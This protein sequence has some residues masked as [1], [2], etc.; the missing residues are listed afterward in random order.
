MIENKL[1]Y[2]TAFLDMNRQNWTSFSRTFDDYLTAFTPYIDMF[3]KLHD[4]KNMLIYNYEM[5]IYIDEIHYDKILA[6][7]TKNIPVKVIK[8]NR[9]FLQ[10]HFPMW[11]LLDR[12]REIMNSDHYKTTF[13][14]R[15]NF[16][17]NTIPEYTMINH[18]KI[19]FLKHS[20]VKGMTNSEFICWTDFGYFKLDDYKMENPLDLNCFNKNT[21]NYSII[22]PI[23]DS[24]LDV[25][26]TMI[27][28]PETIGGFFFLGRWNIIL[29]Y[30]HKIT[31]NC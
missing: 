6:L 29:S 21:I 17:E 10:E 14:S 12:E 20:L 18:I 27:N 23:V 24:D 19:E 16:P 4:D 15:L 5:I 25:Y 2:V 11:K 22:N 26:N 31:N 9:E 1:C 3:N 30:Y 7:I 28:A 8:I 13:N